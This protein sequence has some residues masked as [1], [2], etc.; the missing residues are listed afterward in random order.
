MTEPEGDKEGWL[1]EMGPLVNSAISKWEVLEKDRF[2]GKRSL[3][4]WVH[5]LSVP[6]SM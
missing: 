4:L 6:T 5:Y 1:P 3:L 2:N